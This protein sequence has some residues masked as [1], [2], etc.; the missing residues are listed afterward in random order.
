[1]EAAVNAAERVTETG[2]NLPNA[3]EGAGGDS[4]G[5]EKPGQALLDQYSKILEDLDGIVASHDYNIIFT[6]DGTPAIQIAQNVEEDAN[7]ASRERTII[8]GVNGN[9]VTVIDVL[10]NKAD[11]VAETREIHYK[12]DG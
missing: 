11:E 4:A 1:M 3:G 5:G 12:A 9:V 6:A 10:K 8:F 7:I 2:G